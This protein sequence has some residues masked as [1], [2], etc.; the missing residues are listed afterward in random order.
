MRSCQMRYSTFTLL[1]WWCTAIRQLAQV[2]VSS[3]F[4]ESAKIKSPSFIFIL[5]GERWR[6]SCRR[7]R[8]FLLRRPQRRGPLGPYGRQ[9]LQAAPPPNSCP[10]QP[11]PQHGCH[12]PRDSAPAMV[13]PA[14]VR[15]VPC[16]AVCRVSSRSCF[17]SACCVCGAVCAAV[18][19]VMLR[20]PQRFGALGAVRRSSYSTTTGTHCMALTPDNTHT[21][22]HHR[23]RTPL[24]THARTCTD[25]RPA[26][27]SKERR[28]SLASGLPFARYA[29]ELTAL[30]QLPSVPA[31]ST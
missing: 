4:E 24:D 5:P 11:C 31:N 7:V 30:E 15:V 21:H 20:P 17:S 26:G 10:P 12:F 6:D 18:M 14:T 1:R 3:S 27:E 25:P 13:R 16:R 23:T 22:T 2:R 9:P 28:A 8:L 19:C 29:E